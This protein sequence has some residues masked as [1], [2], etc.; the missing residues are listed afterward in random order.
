MELV[1]IPTRFYE[2]HESRDLDTPVA[3]KWTKRHVWIDKADPAVPELLNDAEYYS[4][5]YG[6]SDFDGAAGLRASAKATVK[7]LK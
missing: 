7:A 4:D 5:P 2:D 3:V 1:R 6:P